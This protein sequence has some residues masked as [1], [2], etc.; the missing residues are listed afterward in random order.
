MS[1]ADLKKYF[2]YLQATNL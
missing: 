2:R 1:L